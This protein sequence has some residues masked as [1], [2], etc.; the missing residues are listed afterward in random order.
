MKLTKLG[1]ELFVPE[2]FSRFH[3][4]YADADGTKEY[5]GITT[6]LG[7][8][9]KPALISWAAKMAAEYIAEN[10]I[11]DGQIFSLLRQS[12]KNQKPRTPRSETRRLTQGRTLMRLWRSMS[13]NA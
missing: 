9:A 2:N 13:V 1:D 11:V 4:Y 12:S 10:A 7:V 8:I 5:T 3:H 6:V